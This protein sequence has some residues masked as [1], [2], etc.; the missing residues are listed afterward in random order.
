MP[1]DAAVACL[2]PL[3]VAPSPERW[4]G[5]IPL[6]LAEALP[7]DAKVG[8][9]R[10]RF[11]VICPDLEVQA[12]GTVLHFHVDVLFDHDPVFDRD[13]GVPE[14]GPEAEPRDVLL[15]AVGQAQTEPE[16]AVVQQLP[17]RPGRDGLVL[18]V[19]QTDHVRLLSARSFRSNLSLLVALECFHVS[20]RK[21]VYF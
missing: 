4:D 10:N 1:E 7:C 6:P 18:E 5:A 2:L 15:G 16:A 8:L 9:C 13:L 19:V 3:V 20:S 17:A 14:H 12:D 21:V 11:Q